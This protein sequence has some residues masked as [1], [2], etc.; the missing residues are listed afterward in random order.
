[1]IG[2]AVAFGWF[3]VRWQIANML[4]SLT[5]PTAPNAALVAEWS[6][7]LSPNDPITSWLRA[8]IH[9]DEFTPES[10][11]RAVAGFEDMVRAAPYD[12]RA[13]VELGRGLEQA[14]QF[15][16]AEKAFL[17]A[18]EL[19]PNYSYTHWHLGN[20]YL[21]QNREN[22][23][24][25]RFRFAA[26]TSTEYREQVFAI[27]WDYFENDPKKL[28]ELA[29]ADPE[30][31]AGLA[32]FY[33]AKE[34]A[35]ESLRIWNS[36]S[37]DEKQAHQDVARIVT[38]ALYDKRFYRSAV[39]FVSQLGLE[40]QAKM[41]AVQNGGFEGALLEDAQKVFFNWKIVKLEKVE[42]RTD[43]AKKHE[44]NRSLRLNF[45]GFSGIEVKNVWQVVAVQASTRYRL[46]FYVRTENLKS[47]GTPLFE[48]V[49]ANDDKLIATSQPFPVDTSDWSEIRVD[50]ATP[51]NAEGVVIRLDRAYCGDACPIVGSVFIDAVKM[52]KL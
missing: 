37:G 42:V 6:H 27:A 28:E 47:A 20:F 2:A 34:L 14:E 3:A 13:W 51:A 39:Q 48:V 11:A 33:A 52:E 23:A 12:H 18:V 45:T 40:S 4:A 35:P 24:I 43:A 17:R 9:L 36:L 21:R 5:Q 16:R 26:E 25:E 22:E 15:E 50:F 30:V 49:N 19:A 10:L 7:D 1:V 32:K 38:Q 31:R 46:S 44:G 41:D 29:G 8:V